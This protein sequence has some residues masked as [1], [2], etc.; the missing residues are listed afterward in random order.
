MHRR[1]GLGIL[2]VAFAILLTTTVVSGHGQDD[3]TIV[4]T[5]SGTVQGAAEN[6]VIAFKGIPYAA[7]P[8][9]DLRWREPQPAERGKVCS[10]QLH[11]EATARSRASIL[12]RSRQRLLRTACL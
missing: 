6:G 5:Q 1:F 12:S 9:G 3:P 8:V 2:M 7:P 10:R 11:S 4:E